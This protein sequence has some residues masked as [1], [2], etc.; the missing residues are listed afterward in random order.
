MGMSGHCDGSSRQLRMVTIV[1]SELETE[2]AHRIAS[3][4]VSMIA[5]FRREGSDDEGGE[6]GSSS[7]GPWTI[8]PERGCSSVFEHQERTG[9][10]NNRL[11][12][13]VQSRWRPTSHLYADIFIPADLSSLYRSL[14]QCA[15]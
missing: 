11:L 13:R 14:D 9:G 10:L 4:K 7:P 12:F 6:G 2:S 15:D 3:I 1:V 8:G 5:A